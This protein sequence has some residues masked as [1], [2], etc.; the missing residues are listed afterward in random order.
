L[1]EVLHLE[2]SSLLPDNVFRSFVIVVFTLMAFNF[3]AP[4]S[5]PAFG[6]TSTPAFGAAPAATPVFGASSVPTFGAALSPFGGGVSTPAYSF[7]TGGSLFGGASAST[8]L[9]G[10]APAAAT[11]FP[12]FG[13]GGATPG[14]F[15]A[16]SPLFGAPQQQQQQPTALTT[17]ENQTI[18]H[19]TT[20]DDLSPQAQQYLLELE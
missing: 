13:G 18:S 1:N 6:A 5:T 14:A 12:L 10:A 16:P 7:S 3:G 20:W 2:P 4:Q 11:P 8:P 15:G 9:F 17:K 19:G